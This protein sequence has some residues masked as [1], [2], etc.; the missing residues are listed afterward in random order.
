MGEF[1]NFV[2]SGIFPISSVLWQVLL[3]KHSSLR[4][5]NYLLLF[6]YSFWKRENKPENHFK[7]ME[8]KML[9]LFLLILLL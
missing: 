6:I 5:L 3:A 2:I 9:L 7:L 4:T 8:P 1:I